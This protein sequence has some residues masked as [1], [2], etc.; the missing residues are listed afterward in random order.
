MVLRCR[1]RVWFHIIIQHKNARFQKPRLLFPNHLFQ[2]Q[3]GV[4]VPRSTDGPD[5]QKVHAKV[6]ASSECKALSFPAEF[7]KLLKRCDK[8]FNA[9]GTYVEK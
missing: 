9:L 4:T 6:N 2:L 1:H 3:Q 5:L 7:L 8:C